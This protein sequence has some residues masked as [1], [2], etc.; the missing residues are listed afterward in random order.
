MNPIKGALSHPPT[1]KLA[2]SSKNRCE[3]YITCHRKWPPTKGSFD[4]SMH[5]STPHQT[6]G[7]S[8]SSPLIRTML[9]A[10]STSIK[11]S[12]C[13]KAFSKEL[14]S[15]SRTIT[16]LDIV[17]TRKTRKCLNHGEGMISSSLQVHEPWW[18]GN[19]QLRLWNKQNPML[20]VE[21][22]NMNRCTQILGYVKDNWLCHCLDLPSYE[23]LCQ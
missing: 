20:F 2:W 3:M 14:L 7:R 1:I 8:S 9:T 17:V 15:P 22:L 10:R 16:P 13:F 11:S 18:S 19:L 12:A 5:Q 21:L 4:Q 6:L 23:E